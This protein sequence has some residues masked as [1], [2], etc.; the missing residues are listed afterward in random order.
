MKPCII[1]LDD[2]QWS[3]AT[4]LN[5]LADLSASRRIQKLPFVIIGAY[6]DNEVGEGHILRVALEYMKLNA[7]RLYTVEVLPFT[8]QE[9]KE[10]LFEILGGDDE[11]VANITPLATLLLTK[12]RGNLF[13]FIEV[14][15]LFDGSKLVVATCP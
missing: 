15:L 14:H 4:E 9:M 13:L 7:V 2:L 8:A 10:L 3:S 12:S 5:F 1:A 6:R 11:V